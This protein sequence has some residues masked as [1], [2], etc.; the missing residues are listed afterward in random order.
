MNRFE[1][2]TRILDHGQYFKVVCGAGNEDP[3]EVAALSMVYTLAGARGIDISAHV[4][5]VNACMRGI[6]KAIDL[7]PRLGRTVDLRPFVNVSVGLKGDPHVR[8]AVIDEAR[9]TA[10]G[11]CIQACEQEAIDPENHQVITRRCIGCGKCGEVCEVGAVDYVSAKVDFRQI[12][13]TCIDAGAENIELHAV[14]SDDEAVMRDWTEIAG[15]LP[16]QYISMCLDRSCLS[17]RHLIERIGLAKAIVGD[18][19]IIQADG[20][21]M[22]GGSDNYNTTLQAVAIADIVS[23]SRIP[24]KLLLSGGTNSKTG[25]F[26]SMSGVTVNG[27]SIGTYARKLVR[28]QTA[29]PGFEENDMLIQDAVRKA[30]WLVSENL[31]YIE[32]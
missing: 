5:I 16:G 14:V 18:R 12:L 22:S 24:L 19:L 13:P 28:E 27:V 2:L 15:I 6:D 4:E 26:A 30:E 9:C 17:D 21:P 32:H 25:A 20:A 11:L 1:Q 31:K 29:A 8:K 23:K 3:G 7:A 10:C